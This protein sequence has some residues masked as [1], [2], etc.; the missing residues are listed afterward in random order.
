MC[1]EV[2]FL[3]HWRG[4]R[5][6]STGRYLPIRRAGRDSIPI[7]AEPGHWRTQAAHVI[8]AAVNSRA[9]EWYSRRENSPPEGAAAAMDKKLEEFNW[10][11]G[12][13]ARP[14][15]RNT[16]H[17][18]RLTGVSIGCQL[19]VCHEVLR[20]WM[21]GVSTETVVTYVRR[22]YPVGAVGRSLMEF[23]RDKA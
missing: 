21:I 10:H 18:G 22:N 23:L 7:P 2:R 11:V 4:G 16:S 17:S 6:A 19:G 1:F 8:Q 14:V 9:I 12:D 20:S 13:S 5:Q 3:K 15:L